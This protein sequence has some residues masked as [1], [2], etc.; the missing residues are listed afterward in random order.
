MN[1]ADVG[2]GDARRGGGSS[3]LLE[4]MPVEDP[5]R[6]EGDARVAEVTLTFREPG[7]N[8]VVRQERRVVYPGIRGCSPFGVTSTPGSS[9]R[10]S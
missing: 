4:L 2:E 10:A 3:L 5:A 8:R 7:T 6:A 1:H 9:R